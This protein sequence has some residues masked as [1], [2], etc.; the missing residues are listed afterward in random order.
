VPSSG[1]TW[2]GLGRS[3]AE[4]QS[5]HFLM[6]SAITLPTLKYK[7]RRGLR[8]RH[9]HVVLG[10]EAGRCL[11]SGNFHQATSGFCVPEGGSVGNTPG[12]AGVA[13]DGKD[14]GNGSNESV[15][16]TIDGGPEAKLEILVREI[17][18]V[19]PCYPTVLSPHGACERPS[20]LPARLHREAA[21]G[22]EWSGG[23]AAGMEVSFVSLRHSS[24]RQPCLMGSVN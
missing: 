13:R 3:G 12:A 4:S 15:R 8:Y 24:F 17:T 18:F 5:R 22:D 6:N 20:V 7:V 9:L 19:S 1:R 21:P 11:K 10:A 16:C 2:A 23:L 14:K